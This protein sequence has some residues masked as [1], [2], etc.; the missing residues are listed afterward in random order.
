MIFRLTPELYTNDFPANVNNLTIEGMG[1]MAH[2]VATK[3][4]PNG[5]AEF[6]TGGSANLTQS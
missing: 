5:K 1:G 3:M 4:V 6:V 2:I